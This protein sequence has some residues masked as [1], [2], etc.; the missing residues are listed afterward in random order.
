MI[1][2]ILTAVLFNKDE[3]AST[4]TMELNL[5]EKTTSAVELDS[6]QGLVNAQ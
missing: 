5:S 4:E 6:T 2:G 3:Q 1:V